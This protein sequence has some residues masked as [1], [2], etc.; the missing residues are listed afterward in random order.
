MRWLSHPHRA[1]LVV[2]DRSTCQRSCP[3]RPPYMTQ[4][5]IQCLII[6]DINIT[7]RGIGRL[8]G[9]SA[10]GSMRAPCR[11]P[12]GVAGIAACLSLSVEGTQKWVGWKVGVEWKVS[13]G[14]IG[15]AEIKSTL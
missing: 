5:L 12:L 4:A 8:G 10:A 7:L 14:V 9:N 2:K 15:V 11:S 6:S 3:K 1:P 13:L